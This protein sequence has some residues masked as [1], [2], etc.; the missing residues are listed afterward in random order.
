MAG[1]EWVR[2]MTLLF[3]VLRYCG[4]LYLVY[5]GIC[6]LLADP[7]RLIDHEEQGVGQCQRD[8]SHAGYQFAVGFVQ[9]MLNPKNLIFYLSLFSAL[10]GNATSV[11]TRTLYGIWMVSV[12]FVWDCS[13]ALVMG[14]NTV[15]KRFARLVPPIEK[16][17]GVM[18]ICFGVIFSM[19]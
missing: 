18:L 2:Q 5:L 14:N 3:T 10:I 13:V 15:K 6:L 11:Q 17:C 19:G 7:R 16:I 8:G 12:V 1:L 4:A 9:A